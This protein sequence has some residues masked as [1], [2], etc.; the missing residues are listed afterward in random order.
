MMLGYWNR[1]EET[2][3]ALR[4]GW[5]HTGDAGYMDHDGYLYL[6]NRIKDMIIVGGANVYSAEAENAV[7]SH[8]AVAACA[9]IGV[10]DDHTGERV[11]AVVALEPGHTADAEGIR[12]H[13]TR[14][15][16][17]YKTPA[18]CEFVDTLPLSPAGKV[19]KHE[20]RKPHWE[21]R[22]RQIH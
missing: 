4:G 13:C 6:V 2:A 7:A 21:G 12:A 18:T 9:V 11:H 1:P 16:A 5:L 15:I 22:S 20:L 3:E 8:P 19:L 17:A 10:P 14:L